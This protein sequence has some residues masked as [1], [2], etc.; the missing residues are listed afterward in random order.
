M[1]LT[2]YARQQYLFLGLTHVVILLFERVIS[3]YT[4]L[5]YFIFSLPGIFIYNL[6]GVFQNLENAT[7]ASSYISI[8]NIYKLSKNFLS[9]FFLLITAYNYKFRKY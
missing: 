5:I 1:S 3:I 2:I 7:S 9:Y 4:F 8:K 6:W